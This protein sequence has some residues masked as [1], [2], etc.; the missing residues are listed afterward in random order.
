MWTA[1]TR[2][3][4][5]AVSTG[6]C[7][8]SGHRTGELPCLGLCSLEDV[9]PIGSRGP[10]LTYI[11]F[12]ILFAN[13]LKSRCKRL[14]VIVALLRTDQV[15]IKLDSKTVV[16]HPITARGQARIEVLKITTQF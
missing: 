5:C 3:I 7:G 13:K 16:M 14:L 11:R 12:F 1:R 6:T 4:G 10:T 9:V 8:S 15:Q 2:L